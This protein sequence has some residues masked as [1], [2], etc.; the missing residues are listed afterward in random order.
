MSK[1]TPD[2]PSH[3]EI[4][5]RALRSRSEPES[6]P[7]RPARPP[8]SQA[9]ATPPEKRHLS[10]FRVAVFA[11][12]LLLVAATVLCVLHLRR[13]REEAM[14]TVRYVIPGREDI[15]QRVPCG[16]T[17][18]LLGPVDGNGVAFLS[19]LDADGMEE[20]RTEIPVYGDLTYTAKVIPVLETEEHVAYLRAD[21]AGLIL[22][23]EKVLIRDYVGILRELLDPDLS[24]KGRFTDVPEEDGCFEAAALLKDLGIFTDLRLHPDEPLTR[25]ELIRT[26][27]CFVPEEK[28]EYEFLD[29]SQDDVYYPWFC[30]AAARGWIS[31]GK[32]VRAAADASV[33]RGEL[34]HILNRVLGRSTE[35]LLSPADTGTLLDVPST[36]EYHDDLAEAAIPHH[37]RIIGGRE[38]WTVS[39]A[40]PLHEPGPVFSGVRLHWIDE[41]GSPV[42]DTALGGLTFT[43]NGEITSGDPDLDLRLWNLLET[44]VD[45]AV[46]TREEMLRTVYDYVVH[47][48][49]YR[50]GN[51]LERGAE[52]WAVKE[53]LRMLRNG[54]SNCYGYAA[55]FYELARFL[56]YDARIYSGIVL[57]EQ[58]VFYT[59]EGTR[60]ISPEA[61]TPHGWVEI[62]FDGVDYIFDPEYEY[63][64]SGLQNMF[65]ADEGI[66]LQYGY[67]K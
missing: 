40:L 51:V 46:M 41:S 48:F 2:A 63:R 32:L 59:E 15:C 33:S 60:V 21:E 20:T 58:R 43:R 24:G 23:G 35:H 1:Q 47:N 27:C 30:T 50:N 54:G 22:P 52:G 16:E 3:R 14:M 5:A 7:R 10:L 42:V 39:E 26:L 29:L 4:Q 53:A 66:R 44:L 65:M 64:S 56:G 62:A 8:L 61:Y 18:E 6:H 57:G 25:G 45:P 49:P 13:E 9:P 38:V 67:M 37:Y 19:W 36:H 55:L 28:G 12:Q 17:A 11:V 34:A 31:S